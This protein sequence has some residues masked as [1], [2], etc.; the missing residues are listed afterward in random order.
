MSYAIIE[1]KGIIVKQVDSSPILAES[2]TA[3]LDSEDDLNALG[4]N[5]AAGSV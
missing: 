5:W 1:Q 3:V 4:T 2:I